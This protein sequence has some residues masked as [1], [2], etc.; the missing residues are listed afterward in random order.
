[1]KRGDESTLR[2]AASAIAALLAVVATYAVL[3]GFVVLT[4]SEPNPALVISSPRIPMFWRIGIGAYAGGFVAMLVYF[5]GARDAAKT[6]RVV[7]G[8]VGPV[9]VLIAVQGLL[10][11]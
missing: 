6:M 2:L 5:L 10:L 9:A 7:L 8:A 11:P 4:Q 3:R 1:M